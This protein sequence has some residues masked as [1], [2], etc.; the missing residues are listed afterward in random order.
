M[1][2]LFYLIFVFTLIS[3]G[4]PDIDNVPDYKNVVLSDEEIIDYCSNVYTDKKNIDKCI[5]DY[6]SKN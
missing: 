6:K 4:Y 2:Y 5:N 3:C 1:K